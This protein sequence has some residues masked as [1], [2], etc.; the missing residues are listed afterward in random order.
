VYEDPEPETVKTHPVAVPALEKSSLAIP[1][2]L[3]DMVIE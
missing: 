2:S 3:S 1:L